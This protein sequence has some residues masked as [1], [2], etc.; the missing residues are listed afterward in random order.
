MSFI[1]RAHKKSCAA[2]AFVLLLTLFGCGPETHHEPL[3][4]IL[5]IVMDTT[6]ADHCSVYGYGR[7][8][9]PALRALAEKGTRFTAAYAPMGI[10]GPSHASLF[11]SKHP[12]SL[13]FV[14]NGLR[15]EEKHQTL[16]EY[17]TK[18]GYETAGIVSSFVL[19]RKFGFAQGF[20]HYDDA[21]DPTEVTITH[22]EWEGHEVPDGA[23]DRRGDYTTERALSW[24]SGRSNTKSPFFAFVHY[25]DPHSPYTPPSTVAGTF[26]AAV[27]SGKE[28]AQVVARYDEEIAFVDQAI[29]DLLAGLDKLNLAEDT[30]VIVT[31]DHGEGLT[32][33]G[34]WQHGL[35]VYEEEVRVPLIIRWPGRVRANQTIE[36]PVVLADAYPTLVDLLELPVPRKALEGMSLGEALRGQNDLNPLRPIHLY[37]RPFAD[38]TKV[39]GVTRIVGDEKQQLN[40][41][42]SGEQFALREGEWKYTLAPAENKTG[43]F[44]L[45]S[46]PLEIR[47]AATNDPER[48]QAMN[49]QLTRWVEDHRKPVSKDAVLTT[50]DREAL[51]ALG[52]I[53]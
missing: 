5:L 13:G 52:Y 49:D 37:R 19:D 27:D 48:A 41:H 25:M 40:I 6:R 2:L 15:L 9:T 10:T 51:E 31:A 12:L 44:N 23:F 33:R 47:N 18:N 34:Y 26:E 29:G 11:T 50:L 22:A 4:N 46:D 20:S 30:I 21:F 35:T 39:S 14:Q 36:E 43:L 7:D 38:G 16:A 17:L 8:T 53:E 3:P 32:Q 24:I 42:V 1:G 45:P 28:R